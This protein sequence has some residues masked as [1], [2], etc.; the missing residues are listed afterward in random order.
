MTKS[1]NWKDEDQENIELFSGLLEEF[2][3]DPRS[4]NWGSQEKQFLRFKILSEIGITDQDSILDIG[5]GL[6]DYYAWMKNQA[7]SSQYTGVDITKPLIEKASDTYP[8]AQFY[9]EDVL[10]EPIEKWQHDYVIASGI[11]SKRSK[12][13]MDFFKYAVDGMFKLSKKGVAFNSLSGWADAIEDTEFHPDP[14]EVMNFCH[15]LT[16][17]VV[18]R[19]DYHPGDFTIYMYKEYND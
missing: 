17:K 15:S 11:F 2:G 18:L 12:S 5:C 10:A 13:A 16:R 1:A 7:L 3:N 9:H 6:G 4:L 8:D 19:H 14:A